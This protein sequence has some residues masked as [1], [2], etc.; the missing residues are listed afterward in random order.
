MK[1]KKRIQKVAL[2]ELSERQLKL[3]ANMPDSSI[4]GL[5]ALTI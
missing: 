2:Q 4:V 1:D 3:P 5:M